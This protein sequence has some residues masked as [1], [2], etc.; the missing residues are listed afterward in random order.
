MCTCLCVRTYMFITQIV[1]SVQSNWLTS[2]YLEGPIRSLLLITV[3]RM[4]HIPSVHE[5]GTE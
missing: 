1:F 5:L 2:V 4:F 3:V